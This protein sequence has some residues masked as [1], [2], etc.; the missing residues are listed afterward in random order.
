MAR[1][2]QTILA[3]YLLCALWASIG[4]DD[5]PLDDSYSPDDVH[6]ESQASALSDIE[7]LLGYIEHEGIDASWWS[8][9]QLAHDLWLT[10]NG[11]GAGFWDRGQDLP[12]KIL[13]EYAQALGS[14]D[15]YVGDDGKV[16][17]S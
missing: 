15:A 6:L 12:G 4:D 7:D 5:E 10:R 16:Y 14:S 2:P 1:N 9:E 8:D 13:T 11:H 3:H 17:L